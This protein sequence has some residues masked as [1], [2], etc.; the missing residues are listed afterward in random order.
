VI[1]QVIQMCQ[2][3]PRIVVPPGSAGEESES[4]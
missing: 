2:G 3:K 1:E 4:R